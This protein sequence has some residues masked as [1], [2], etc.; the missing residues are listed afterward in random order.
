M[1]LVRTKSKSID[2]VS[3]FPTFSPIKCKERHDKIGCYIHWK[4]CKYDGIL[5]CEKWYEHQTE[6]Q[7][8][9]KRAAIFLDLAIET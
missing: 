5:D 4:I 9:A 1:Y 8:E 6:A 2:Q 3:V 7:T